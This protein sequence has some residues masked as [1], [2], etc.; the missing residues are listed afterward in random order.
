LF[1]EG[2]EKNVDFSSVAN[3]AK[4][5]TPKEIFYLSKFIETK[6]KKIQ[7]KKTLELLF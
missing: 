2:E 6:T 7:R 3:M 1:I 5:E 4:Y